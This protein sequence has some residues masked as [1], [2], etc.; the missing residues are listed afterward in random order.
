MKR[1]KTNLLILFV[2]LTMSFAGRAQTAL[3]QNA[4]APQ[5]PHNDVK[6]DSRILYHNG[7]VLS[8]HRIFI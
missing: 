3:A 6:T 2:M 8:G 7:P 1:N 5:N 4:L